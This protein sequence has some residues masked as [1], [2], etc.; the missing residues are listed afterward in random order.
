MRL[1]IVFISA[2]ALFAAPVSAET[3][4]NDTVLA[5]IG[6]GLDD[7]VVIAK[8]KTSPSKFELSTD[9]V[10]A[11]KQK[12]VSARVLAAMISS[13]ASTGQSIMSV[14][15]PDPT[16]PHPSG[17]YLGGTTKMTRIE[18][19]T[20]KQARTSGMLGSLLTSGLSGLRVKAALTGA[21]A[22]TSTTERS[23]A[24]YFYFEAAAQGL[25]VSGGAVTSPSE[26]SLIS[27]ESKSDKR[28]A[29][30]GSIG[31]GGSKSGI[32][33]KD[34]YDFAVNQISPGVYKVVPSEPLKPGEYGFVARGAGASES[35]F[36]RV[37]DFSVK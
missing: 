14:D 36:I 37:F 20:T 2:V 35:S 32:R 30:I 10:L 26:F 28:E 15:S 9:Q 33:D 4:T 12:G 19:T 27:L 8:I 23:P 3:L 17:I 24:F 7:E 34:Q 16:V 21:H 13:T 22:A 29:V 5:L 11:L 25:G 31:L 18:S 6:A 1:S